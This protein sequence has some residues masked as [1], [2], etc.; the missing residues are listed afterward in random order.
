MRRK[1][2][3]RSQEHTM[4]KEQPSATNG[5]GKNGQQYANK[6]RQKN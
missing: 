3:D 1:S 6:E 5:A 4:G 2:T